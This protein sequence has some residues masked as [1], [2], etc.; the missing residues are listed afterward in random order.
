MLES[1]GDSLVQY[2]KC[3]RHSHRSLRQEVSRLL[4]LGTVYGERVLAE[5]VEALL[6][7]G[8]IGIDQVELA[9]KRREGHEKEQPLRPAPMNLQDG[10]LAR[11]PARTDLRL[12]D[13]RLLDSRKR[14]GE[15]DAS[16]SQ[17]SGSQEKVENEKDRTIDNG[18]GSPAPE[19]H[20][21]TRGANGDR[22]RVDPA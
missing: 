15:P 11:I 7:R 17:K 3:L 18:H 4:A 8:A 21:D 16:P 20:A 6:K 10:R 5:T 19:P 13:R 22:D 2:L 14:T 9:L 1:Y 12:Y